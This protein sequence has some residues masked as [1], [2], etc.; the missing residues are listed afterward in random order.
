MSNCMEFPK[1]YNQFIDDYA[2]E[3]SKQVYTYG[4]RL[5]PVFRVYQMISHYLEKKNSS[6]ETHFL[7]NN[8]GKVAFGKD[9]LICPCISINAEHAILT[10]IGCDG[11]VVSYDLA[12]NLNGLNFIEVNGVT[13]MKDN[14]K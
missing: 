10:V 11:Q 12:P 4:S 7:G 5:I 6:T 3:D 2:F 8:E 9:V 13:F 1:D 14:S